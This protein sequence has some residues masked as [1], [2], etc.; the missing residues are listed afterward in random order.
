MT[1][2]IVHA[3]FHKT[4]TTS[5]QDYLKENR[6]ALKPYLSYYGQVDFLQAGA[7][8]RI[9][10]QRRF[11]WRRLMFR[12]AFGRFLGSVPDA[13]VIVLSRETF[14]GAMPGHRAL[15]GRKLE[16]YSDAAIPLAQ[17]ILRS[18][19]KRFGPGVGVEFLYKLRDRD[20]WLASVHGHLLRSIHLTDDLEEFEVGFASRPDPAAAAARIG[21]A[22]APVPVHTAWLEDHA[23]TPEGPAGAVLDL[24]RV[25]ASLRTGLTTAR[26]RNAGQTANLRA[27]FLQINRASGSRAS[28]KV[29]KEALLAASQQ[30]P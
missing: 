10:G 28:L 18:L 26:R 5:L 19:R 11:W 6:K 1:R 21:A 20:S 7:H 23:S 17:E 25:P 22:L 13:P 16:S 30:K 24:V 8:A 27:Q 4:G 15:G 9:Y 3:G 14:S 29:A 2:V 12:R